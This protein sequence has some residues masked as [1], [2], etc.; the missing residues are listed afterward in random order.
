VTLQKQI[1]FTMGTVKQMLTASL[2]FRTGDL[3]HQT[4]IWCIQN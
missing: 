2:F 1:S 3:Y 4:N